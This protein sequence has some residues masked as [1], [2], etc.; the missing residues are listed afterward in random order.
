M[1]ARVFARRTKATPEDRLAFPVRAQ[2]SIPLPPLSLPA[3][4]A[5]HV[6]VT[7][8]DDLA[9]AEEIARQWAP[10]GV[11]VEIGGP[12]TGMRGEAF[13]PGLYLKPGYVI[14]S[15]GCPN[16]CWFCEVPRREGPVRELPI[17]EGWNVL[18]DNLL[19]CSEAHIKRVFT[20]LYG[21]KFRYQRGPLFTGGLE[22]AR[23]QR[24]HVNAL[25]D[26]QPRAMY[27][28][29]DEP[30]D[31]EPL[32]AAGKLL[33]EA[34]FTLSRRLTYCY[35]LMGYQGDTMA[36]A[37]TRCRE[38]LSVGFWPYAMLWHENTDPEW[39]RLQ[40]CWLAPAIIY[41]REVAR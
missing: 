13:T 40:R 39:E 32:R 10:V 36:A 18:D 35:V 26:L 3:V 17:T 27:F 28:A 12:A 19:A 1:I 8:T 23:L 14:T 2:R 29:Y 16:R 22:A 7:F 11:P 24:W 31:L 30:A 21:Q 38:A 6:S 20:M 5:V 37:E 4:T 15:R 9:R 34:G 33:Q 25:A 41:R